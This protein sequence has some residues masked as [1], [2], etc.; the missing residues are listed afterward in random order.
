M[1]MISFPKKQQKHKDHKKLNFEFYLGT[2]YFLMIIALVLIP[3]ALM[4]LYAFT[5]E[6]NNLISIRFT[7]DHFKEFFRQPTF[8]SSMAESIYLSLISATICL[9]ICY[10]LAFILSRRKLV[11]Q[12]ILV[13]RKST[14]LNSSHV[15][16]SYAVFCLKKKKLGYVT[17]GIS[18]LTV[19]SV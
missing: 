15:R 13:D 7:F 17:I 19:Q 6:S 12:K 3:I 18:S 1:V 5:T 9:I 2:P 14:R 4:V 10:P 16:I 8:I 11:T